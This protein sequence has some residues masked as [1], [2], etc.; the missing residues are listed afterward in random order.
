MKFKRNKW[1]AGREVSGIFS[2]YFDPKSGQKYYNSKPK[3]YFS[4]VV[5]IEWRCFQDLWQILEKFN[6]ATKVILF[7]QAVVENSWFKRKRSG[8]IFRFRLEVMGQLHKKT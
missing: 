4:S 5:W 2:S 6:K 8:E 7:T 1:N 3:I